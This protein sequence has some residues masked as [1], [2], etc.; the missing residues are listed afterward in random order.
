MTKKFIVVR[1]EDTWSDTIRSIE[2]KLFTLNE[3]TNQYLNKILYRIGARFEWDEGWSHSKEEALEIFK[4]EYEKDY[5]SEWYGLTF[6][7]AIEAVG[8]IST[9]YE[10]EIETYEIMDDDSLK[11][12]KDLS[13]Y[14]KY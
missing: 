6:N 3:I 2:Q 10:I 9:K 1:C 14:E 11:F 13:T 5:E 7:E 12:R 4:K 8:G